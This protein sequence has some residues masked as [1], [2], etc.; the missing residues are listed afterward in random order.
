MRFVLL[1]KKNKSIFLVLKGC[2]AKSIE[3]SII[4]IALSINTCEIKSLFTNINKL[5]TYCLLLNINK[6]S[7]IYLMLFA[8]IDK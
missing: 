5:W 2:V 3:R 1:D 6:L 4:Y 7:K 8:L